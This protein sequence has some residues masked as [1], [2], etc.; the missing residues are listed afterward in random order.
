MLQ[1][2]SSAVVRLLSI[3]DGSFLHSITPSTTQIWLFFTRG[4]SAETT[5]ANASGYVLP[6]Q[7]KT[8]FVPS[9]VKL[10][11]PGIHWDASPSTCFPLCISPFPMPMLYVHVVPNHSMLP[12]DF[13]GQA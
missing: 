5:L 9:A 3:A 2:V 12:I 11:N 10:F 8:I 4:W 1:G 13:F 7:D 6:S